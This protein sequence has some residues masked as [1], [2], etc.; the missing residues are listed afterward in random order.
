[1]TAGWYAFLYRRTIS[2]A[3]DTRTQTEFESNRRLIRFWKA[4]DGNT[5][6]TSFQPITPEQY[7]DHAIVISC[8]HSEPGACYFTSVDIIYL[9]EALIGVA[10]STEE[11]NRVRRNLEVFHPMTISK[12]KPKTEDLFKTIMG[13]P[14]PMPRNIEKDIKVFP[15]EIIG[16]ALEKVM[17]KYVSIALKMNSAMGLMTDSYSR[18]EIFSDPTHPCV[19][20]PLTAY[21]V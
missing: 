17:E 1:L 2:R 10:F 9:L 15:W 13:F 7:E 4:Q 21:H 18:P 20:R 6:H 8:I 16:L 5:V 11:K 12:T 19:P 14:H 3:N